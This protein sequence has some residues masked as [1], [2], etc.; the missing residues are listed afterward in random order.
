MTF[1]RPH[2]WGVGVPPQGWVG[3]EHLLTGVL[4]DLQPAWWYNWSPFAFLPD[5]APGYI[6]ML[7]SG[8][9]AARDCEQLKATIAA[10]PNNVWQFLNE[11]ENIKQANIS[12]ME[13][14]N[15]LKAFLRLAWDTGSPGQYA[16]PGVEMSDKGLVWASEFF[17][18]CRV[19]YL[20]RPAYVTVHCYLNGS[21]GQNQANWD[22]M[23]TAFWRFHA[24]WT[25]ATPVVVS[26]VCAVNRSE[27]EQRIIMDL[28]REKLATDP[29]VVGVA[30]F[31]ANQSSG[32]IFPEAA[33]S[34]YDAASEAV[35]LTPLGE[36]W[37]SLR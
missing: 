7:W 33:L 21:L 36:Y 24:I 27:N 11:P 30:W 6:P 18:L 17:S 25:P 28:A 32:N 13:A 12:P 31:A 29:R 14:L 2:G 22:A 15:G 20:H 37:K 16:A 34:T 35:S 4:Q 9:E 8:T 3:K 1:T 23:W 19:N 26:E 5:A 10:R